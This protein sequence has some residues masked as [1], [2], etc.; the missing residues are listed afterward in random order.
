V[1][2][3]FAL[4]LLLLSCMV[5]ACGGSVRALLGVDDASPEAGREADADEARD[6]GAADA[7]SDDGPH[8]ADAAADAACCIFCPVD[9]QPALTCP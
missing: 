8:A 2:H 4:V 9:G 7:L 1:A 6:V 5:L 3:R